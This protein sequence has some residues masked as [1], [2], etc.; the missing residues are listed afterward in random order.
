MHPAPGVQLSV[1]HDDDTRDQRGGR[2][3]SGGGG[4]PL[5]SCALPLERR[6][7]AAQPR[8]QRRQPQTNVITQY[9]TPFHPRAAE[10]GNADAQFLMATFCAQGRF[11]TPLHEAAATEWLERGAAQGHAVSQLGLGRHRLGQGDEVAAAASFRAAAE[12]RHVEAQYSLA[13]F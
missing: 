8:L 7:Q 5:C 2:G 13:L 6:L 3:H 11:G 1:S 12:Q 10:A 4:R 9:S